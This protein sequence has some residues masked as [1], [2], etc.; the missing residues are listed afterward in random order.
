MAPLVGIPSMNFSHSSSIAEPINC[1]LHSSRPVQN[2]QRRVDT[3][4]RST[5][6]VIRTD[7]IGSDEEQRR[8]VNLVNISH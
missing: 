6:Y 7:T 1:W 8:V 4:K 3:G 5:Y 2:T